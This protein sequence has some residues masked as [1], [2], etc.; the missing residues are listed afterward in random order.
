MGDSYFISNSGLALG[1]ADGVG[2]WKLQGIDAGTYSRGLMANANAYVTEQLMYNRNVELQPLKIMDY[3]FQANVRN[4]IVGTS[5]ALVAVVDSGN[6]LRVLNVGDSVLM[7]CRNGQIAY[8]TQEQQHS[9]NCPFQLGT[10]SYDKPAMGEQHSY[11]L[12]EGDIVILGTDGVFDNV[13]DHEIQS[14]VQQHFNQPGDTNAIA[15]AIAQTAVQHGGSR[16]TRT[17]FCVSA[18]RAGISYQ[19]G[20]ADDITVVVSK[21]SAQPGG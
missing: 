11:P 21:V 10:N 17:P 7:L 9:F 20:K 16:T 2:A 12:Q 13:H 5:T 8:R 14:I 6:V 4:Q 18:N 19:G 15:T 1:I 3:A